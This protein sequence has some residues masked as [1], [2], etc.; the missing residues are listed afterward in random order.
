MSRRTS[1]SLSAALLGSI[2]VGG[3]GP[4]VTGFNVANVQ[5]LAPVEVHGTR[6]LLAACSFD[7]DLV[8]S[9]LVPGTNPDQVRKTIVPLTQASGLPTPDP[10]TVEVCTAVGCSASSAALTVTGSQP[11]PSVNIAL[12]PSSNEADNCT[13]FGINA[14]CVTVV[15]TGMFPGT[16]TLVNLGAGPAVVRAV[17]GGSNVLAL[18]SAMVNQNT[19]RV[20]FPRSL[21]NGSYKVRVANDARYGGQTGITTGTFLQN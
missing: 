17:S 8:G 1:C 14:V 13:F 7:G 20:Y 19:L 6:L 15:G 5:R 11:V 2:L 4:T 9:W 16:A 18:G 3:C 21:P 12:A 10:S